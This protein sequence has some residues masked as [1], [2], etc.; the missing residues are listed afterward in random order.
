MLARWL[1]GSRKQTVRPTP[2]PERLT[3]S[4]GDAVPY[5]GDRLIIEGLK[6]STIVV[7]RGGKVVW[8]GN[9]VADLVNQVTK[10]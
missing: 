2:I 9:C 5:P 4:I 6:P 10:C 1:F 3:W 8:V 7:C